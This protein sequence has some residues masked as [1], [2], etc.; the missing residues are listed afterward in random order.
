MRDGLVFSGVIQKASGPKT[1]RIRQKREER[2]TVEGGR[3]GR[4]GIELWY[5]AVDEEV[6]EGTRRYIAH[7]GRWWR[8]TAVTRGGTDKKR[9]E[10]RTMTRHI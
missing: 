2:G 8:T 3:E 6:M 9:K 7:D 1:V 10:A 5:N 4:L